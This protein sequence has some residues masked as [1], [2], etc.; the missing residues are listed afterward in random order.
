MYGEQ[1]HAED[2]SEDLSLDVS[3]LS[4]DPPSDKKD[5][6]FVPLSFTSTSTPTSEEDEEN[7]KYK[8][9]K[10]MVNESRLMELRV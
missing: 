7:G 6:S 5:Q 2:S 10:W 4:L 8:E 3:M 9:R 1:T